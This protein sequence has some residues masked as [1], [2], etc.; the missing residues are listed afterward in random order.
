MIQMLMYIMMWANVLWGSIM[1]GR[2][3]YGLATVSI[4]VAL[5]LAMQLF[6]RR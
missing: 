4:L 2:K 6:N 3:S 1:V 5:I